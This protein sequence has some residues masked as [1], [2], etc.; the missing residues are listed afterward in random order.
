MARSCHLGQNASPSFSKA[1]KP[2]ALILGG[3]A[4][5][6]SQVLSHGHHK[7][8]GSYEGFSAIRGVRGRFPATC[9]W[10]LG[11]TGTLCASKRSGMA[12]TADCGRMIPGSEN[13]NYTNVNFSLASI[14]R[15]G[16]FR[17]N[18]TRNGMLS[19]EFSGLI[20][21]LLPTHL[22]H[23]PPAHALPNSYSQAPTHN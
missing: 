8:S 5:Q 15:H 1:D 6:H 19:P 9:A 16:Y 17:N 23:H 10:S 3:R 2:I 4:D 22:P 20:I 11:R 21:K 18:N 7:N 14:I 12:Q 13:S